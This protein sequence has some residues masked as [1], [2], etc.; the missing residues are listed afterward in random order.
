MLRAPASFFTLLIVTL[1]SRAFGQ[2]FIPDPSFSDDGLV[3]QEEAGGTKWITSAMTLCS[4][5]GIATASRIS[6][7]GAY[8][9]AISRYTHTG[10]PLVEFGQNGVVEIPFGAI[11]ANASALIERPD[12]KLD[13]V[14]TNFVTGGV[15]ALFVV[16]LL[17]D[18]DLDPAWG[19]EG[20]ANHLFT[21]GSAFMDIALRPTGELIIGGTVS[22]EMVAV[23]FNNMGQLDAEFGI[24]G[25]ATLGIPGRSVAA[26]CL[27][28]APSGNLYL[29]GFRYQ[30]SD[31]AAWA[32]GGMDPTGDPLEYFGS[33]GVVVIDNVADNAALPTNAQ[34][35]VASMTLDVQNNIYFGASVALTYGDERG[36][37]GK[38]LPDGSLDAAFATNGVLMFRPDTTRRV[39]CTG[40]FFEPTGQVIGIAEECQ[41]GGCRKLL[42]RTDLAGNI[43]DPEINGGIT[44]DFAPLGANS[45]SM[46]YAT[47]LTPQGRLMFAGAISE[48]PF[49]RSVVK[50]F[51]V[52]QQLTTNVEP[53]PPLGSSYL[54]APNPCTGSFV[55]V[56]NGREGTVRVMHLFDGRGALVADY[57][58]Q[59]REANPQAGTTYQLPA[60]TAP[61]LY[62]LVL[63]DSAGRTSLL[64]VVE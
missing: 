28:L 63:T 58:D 56:G 44:R 47:A 34:E 20:I 27:A 45:Y 10:E 60:R 43:L 50:A 52:N 35:M 23:Q 57:S 5:G 7:N 21:G 51:V 6:R 30:G 53:L 22:G 17:P 31:A 1:C 41:G 2:S 3:V 48:S 33:N 25:L 32:F 13:V 14:C 39:T 24:Q 26:M 4:D 15:L 29:G 37:I 38:L 16:Q 49:H 19:Q 59:A 55:L 61:G 18:G 8:S 46:S 40:I 42:L 54:L 11:G 12:G 36:A 64:V 62:Q 9:I